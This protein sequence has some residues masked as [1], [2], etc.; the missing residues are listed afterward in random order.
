M[1]IIRIIL[2]ILLLGLSSL[3]FFGCK[4]ESPEDILWKD[5]TGAVTFTADMGGN[6]AGGKKS[7]SL[8]FTYKDALF[9]GDSERY[10]KYL[11]AFAYGN[12]FLNGAK[13]SIFTLYENARFDDVYLSPAYDATSTADSVGYV[14][15]HKLAEN[16]HIVC[17]S[18]RGFNYG[19][20]WMGN[21]TV[22][23]SGN[24]EN[25]SLKAREVYTAL[26]GYLNKYDGEIKVLV[27]GY[28]RG[29]GIANLLSELITENS[30][31]KKE[32]LFVYTFCAPRTVEKNSVK[33]YKNVFN[34][35]NS[36][37]VVNYLPPEDFGFYRHGIDVDIYSEKADE[38]LKDFGGI[39]LPKFREDSEK[40]KTAPEFP[41]YIIKTLLSYTK[42][43]EF[44]LN[45]RA[46]YVENYESTL[47]YFIET[48]YSLSGNVLSEITAGLSEKNL[49]ELIKLLKDD[50]LYLYLS[51]FIP[52]DTTEKDAE[53][54][55]NS[56]ILAGFLNY[57][58]FPVLTAYP[59]YKDNF[60]RMLSMHFWETVY[61]LLQNYNGF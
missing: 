6:F 56:E 34:I 54:K 2:L 23:K 15:S 52:C 21:C 19:K 39:T 9:K 35:I 45:T 3:S 48:F 31:V 40:F 37:D 47:R 53:L 5:E 42:N 11:A 8:K 10:N 14:F 28:S 20:E 55:T 29:G 25:F 60:S 44:A 16:T 43:E 12:A 41:S 17:V 32:N 26:C 61:V 22:G 49:T 59:I 33:K 38:L 51:E 30:T 36:A 58:A 57:P 24:H 4:K 46:L 27:T 7:Y 1:R 13:S 50:N 18:V